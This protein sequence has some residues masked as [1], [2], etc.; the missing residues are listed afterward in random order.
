MKFDLIRPCENCPFADTPTRIKFAARERAE[1]IE[2]TAY[3]E[4]FV[5][6][7]H[8]EFVDEDDEGFREEGFHPRLDGSSQHCFGAVAMYLKQSTANVPWQE[9]IE[10]DED[11][12]ERWWS[13]VDMN[14]LATIWEDEEAFMDANDGLDT[15]DR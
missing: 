4:G 14:A 11:L 15:P 12:E 9:A 5:C 13:R 6:H 1:E 7:D 8:A 2:E 3:R 10:E